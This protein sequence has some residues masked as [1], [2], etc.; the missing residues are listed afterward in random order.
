M[1]YILQKSWNNLE[2]SEISS[3]LKHE[4][5]KKDVKLELSQI[6]SYIF[7]LYLIEHE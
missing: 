5:N 3:K 1:N 2:K 4:V 6:E 7:P